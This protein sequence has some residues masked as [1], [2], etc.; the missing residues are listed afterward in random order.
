V[1]ALDNPVLGRDPW[2]SL[3]T[4]AADTAAAGY[5]A[6][7]LGTVDLNQVWRS[8]Q[9]SAVITWTTPRDLPVGIVGLIRHNLTQGAT[10]R[11]EIFADVAMTDRKYDSDTDSELVG[12]SDIWPATFAFDQLDFEDDNWL[13]WQPLTAS[14]VGRSWNRPIWF[15]D[16]RYLHRAGRLTISNPFNPAAFL[17]LGRLEVARGMQFSRGVSLGS[18]RGF[19]PNSIVS[20]AD[21]GKEYGQLRNKPRVFEGTFP[22][23]PRAEADLLGD[24]KD[25]RDVVPE[26]G[27][28][29]LPFPR[30]PSTWHRQFLFCRNTDLGL[31]QFAAPLRDSVPVR[32]REVL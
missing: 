15:N 25:D 18:A 6:S 2:T 21:G 14:L 22:S 24:F 28:L 20:A 8:T 26:R 17:Q 10:F 23:L 1:A 3:V 16:V 29:W 32:F 7:N 13:T 4:F 30:D 12:G 11:L 19:A 31:H 5:P 27:F 9:K